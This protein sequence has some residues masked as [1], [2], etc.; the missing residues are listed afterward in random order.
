MRI[1]T[2]KIPA[3]FTNQNVEVRNTATVIADDRGVLWIIDPDSGVAR[4][5]KFEQP[6]AEV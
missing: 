2:V 6:D 5:V 3:T 1:V 4:L